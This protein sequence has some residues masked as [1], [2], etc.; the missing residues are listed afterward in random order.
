MSTSEV[1]ERIVNAL[2]KAGIPYMLS[3]SFAS[4]Y[5]GSYPSTQD[6]DLIIQATPEQLQP[7]IESLPKAHYYVE[8]DS[9]LEA[10]KHQSMFNVVDAAAGWKIDFMICKSRPFSQEE[11]ARRRRADLHGSSLFVVSA[12]DLIVAK[13]EWAKMGQS[14]RQLEDVRQ[15]VLRRGKKLDRLYVEKWIQ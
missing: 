13:L 12:E 6:I 9:A 15:I 10:M 3:G 5:Y 8:L 11:F 2:E 7:F 14:E 1:F 4:A